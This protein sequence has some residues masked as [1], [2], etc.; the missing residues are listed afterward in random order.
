MSE[1]NEAHVVILET[2]NG[3]KLHSTDHK[4]WKKLSPTLRETRLNLDGIPI[5]VK[6]QSWIEPASITDTCYAWLA[7][8]Q[9]VAF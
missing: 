1:A 8:C 7:E 5:W 2:G 3:L 9:G 6:Y 4:R